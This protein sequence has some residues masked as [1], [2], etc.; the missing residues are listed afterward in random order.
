MK[1]FNLKIK[2]IVEEIADALKEL[3]DK[4]YRAELI[5]AKRE[6]LAGKGEKAKK[7]FKELGI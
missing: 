7:V 2:I 4:N 5:A 6:I 1:K 3:R